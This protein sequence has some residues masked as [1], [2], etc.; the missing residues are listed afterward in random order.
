MENEKPKYKRRNYFVNK[1]FQLNFIMKFCLLIL[2]SALI[3]TGLIMIFSQGTL[4]S[5]FEQSR[6]EIQST[7][8][9]ILPTII[10]TNLITIVLIS[11]AS[12][13]VT[14]FIS[15]KIAGPLFR[16]TLEIDRIAEGDLTVNI[17]LREKDQVTNL[18]DSLNNM[19]NSLRNKIININENLEHLKDS[20]N[21]NEAHD[22]LMKKAEV[23][24]KS[25]E[26]DFRV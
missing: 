9:A 18:A 3:S 1:D 26:T 22:D 10:Y 20:I 15:H 17:R 6:L 2:L 25:M 23:I 8:S 4:T 21:R 14:L 19:T 7:S 5:S 11:L 24:I 12:I 13:T 16:F